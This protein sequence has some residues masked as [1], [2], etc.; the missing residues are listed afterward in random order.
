MKVLVT[1]GSGWI[2]SATIPELLR[3]GHD[4][5]ALARSE[6][7]A[8]AVSALGATPLRGSLD[9]HAVL[10]DAAAAAGGVL[11]LAYK[12]D[13]LFSGN[14]EAALAAD[15]EAIAT[16]GDALAGSGK[17]LVIATGLAGHP[18]DRVVTEDDRPGTEGDLAPRMVA[19]ADLLA[20]ADRDVRAVSVRLAASVHGHDDPGFV[21]M[22]AGAARAAGRAGYLG[23][24]ANHWPA[25][26]R[27]DVARLFRIA[28]EDAPAGAVL[29]GVGEEGVPLRAIAEALGARFG[30][31]AGPVEPEAFGPLAG[32]AGLD[33][34]ASSALT[35]ERYG[36]APE[37][38][39]LVE[40]VAAGAYDGAAA[41]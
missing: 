8:D 30:I 41:R 21:A 22:L 3:A 10:R 11:H 35:R 5:V 32:F 39:T 24:G 14:A 27:D 15:R 37:G 29:H 20:L 26:H 17:P 2:G 23:E 28:L 40:D 13:E 6:A 4:V 25:C 18:A 36:W 34:R 9:D 16:F 38:P 33:V 19:E 7:S 12:H 31:P 1:G